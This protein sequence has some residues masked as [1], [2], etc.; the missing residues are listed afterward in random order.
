MVTLV[1]TDRRERILDVALDLFAEEGFSGT[2][3]V[4]IE[5]RAGLS[6]ASGSFYRHF[7]SKEVLFRAAVAREVERIRSEIADAQAAAAPT[8]D[9]PAVDR[10]AGLTLALGHLRRFDRLFRL[11]FNEGDRMP[12]LRAAIY[13]ALGGSDQGVSWDDGPEIALALTA[14]GGYHL[15]S[16]MQGRPFEDIP[17]D[18]FVAAVARVIQP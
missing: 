8:T 15:F 10:I 11:M 5:R 18:E 14:L 6:P 2:T 13:D 1:A 7:S 9:D 17:E 12:E 4:E 16:R 3:V